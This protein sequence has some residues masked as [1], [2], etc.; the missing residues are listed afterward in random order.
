[1]S[2]KMVGEG[3]EYP[4]TA[5]DADGNPFDGS[6]TDKLNLPP[7]IPLKDFLSVIVYDTQTRF[8]LQTDQQFPSVFSQDKDAKVNADGSVDVWFDPKAPEA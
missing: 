8:M 1:M 5:L 4:W 7:D 6:K 2:E 3:F